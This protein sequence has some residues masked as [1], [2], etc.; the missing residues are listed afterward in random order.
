MSGVIMGCKLIQRELNVVIDYESEA[1]EVKPRNHLL[2]FVSILSLLNSYF[3]FSSIWDFLTTL[4][5]NIQYIYSEKLSA[6]KFPLC[7]MSKLN[8]NWGDAVEVQTMQK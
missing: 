4:F 8:S 2:Y 6:L 1:P 3:S 5:K 7:E